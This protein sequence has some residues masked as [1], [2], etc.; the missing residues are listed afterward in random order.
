LRSSQQ[1]GASMAK[2]KTPQLEKI[3]PRSPIPSKI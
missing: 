2:F 1:L 3:V